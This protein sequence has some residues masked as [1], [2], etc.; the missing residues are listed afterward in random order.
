M[1]SK[2]YLESSIAWKDPKTSTYKTGQFQKREQV[3]YKN[4]CHLYN[5][6]PKGK[7]L[8]QF[9]QMHTFLKNKGLT[10]P[11]I[12]S[13]GLPGDDCLATLINNSYTPLKNKVFSIGLCYKNC[14][15][16]Y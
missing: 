14:E 13:S 15:I 10:E 16:L 5:S 2:S 9:G 12:G 3:M 4:F 6:L 7:I 8:G 1:L 11:F